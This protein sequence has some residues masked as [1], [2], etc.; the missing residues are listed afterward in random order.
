[1]HDPSI[2]SVRISILQFRLFA[3]IGKPQIRLYLPNI[4]KLL[5]RI[6]GAH[7]RR[8]N[9]IIP[10]RPV[11]RRNNTLLITSLQTIN[12]PQHFRGVAASASRIV[13]LEPDL[14]GRVDN[15]DGADGKRD[16]L[17]SDVVQVVLRNHIVQES[18]FAIG[19]GD[20][21]KFDG[22]VLCLV[23][24]VYPLVVRAEVVGALQSK[25]ISVR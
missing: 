22:G 25:H 11:N 24:V 6:L 15:E 1:M 4:A 23:D 8:H 18:D 10:H 13:H 9:N 14:L 19:V 3:N 5:P 17:R 7:T 12:H 2:C 16:A 20:D 21:G